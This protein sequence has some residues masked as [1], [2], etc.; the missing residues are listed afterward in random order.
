MIRRAGRTIYGVVLYLADVFEESMGIFSGYFCR[1]R[2]SLFSVDWMFPVMDVFVQLCSETVPYGSFMH[3]VEG[4]VVGDPNP[5]LDDDQLM[6][7]AF[8]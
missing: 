3:F 4:V 8:R 5:F 6:A 7:S 2:C 1:Q